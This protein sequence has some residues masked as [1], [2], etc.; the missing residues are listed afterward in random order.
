MIFTCPSMLLQVSQKL[1]AIYSE[2]TKIKTKLRPR[3]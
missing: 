2:A 3:W 1:V